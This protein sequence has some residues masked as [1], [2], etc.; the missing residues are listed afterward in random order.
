ML[1]GPAQEAEAGE[2]GS[3]REAPEDIKDED[4][5]TWLDGAF[6]E[7]QWPVCRQRARKSSRPAPPRTMQRASGNTSGHVRDLKI[8]QAHPAKRESAPSAGKM[9]NGRPPGVLP[10]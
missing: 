6:D 5:G 10:S 1:S 7:D 4:G 8:A 2:N 9:R 3:G